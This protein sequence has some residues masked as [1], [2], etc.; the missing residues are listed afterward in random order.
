M[1][2]ICHLAEGKISQI[3]IFRV[4]CEGKIEEGKRGRD[5]T[6]DR[7]ESDGAAVRAVTSCSRSTYLQ[8]LRLSQLHGLSHPDTRTGGARAIKER[9]RKREDGDGD[10][11]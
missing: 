5:G 3:K 9:E 7:N 8:Q 6:G 1:L 11:D 10:K 4:N 2:F